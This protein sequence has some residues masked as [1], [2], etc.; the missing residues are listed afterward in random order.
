MPAVFTF[1]PDR[2]FSK[3]HKPKVLKFQFGDG[4]SV[5]VP[6]GIN[7]NNITWNLTFM[8]RRITEANS[9]IAF[10]ETTKGSD[11]FLWTP[12]GEST[13]YSVIV[14]EWSSTYDSHISKTVSATFTRVFDNL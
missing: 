9:I 3:Q 12:P 5:R 11:S 8:S 10:F 2:N 13:Q 14:E 6:D 1:V 4:Y 7:T